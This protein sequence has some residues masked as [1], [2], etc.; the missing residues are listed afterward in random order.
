MSGGRSRKRLLGAFAALC[1]AA[2]IMAG[3]GAGAEEPLA[4]TTDPERM[5][6]GVV[7][8]RPVAEGETE[9]MRRAGIDSLRLWIPWAAVESTRDHYDW[10]GTD[11]VM[12]DLAAAGIDAFPFLFGT[13]EWAAHRDRF[14]CEREEC[15]P[16][17]PISIET[18]YAFARFAAAAVR[19][20]GPDGLFWQENPDLPQRPIRAWQIWNEPNL[21]RFYEPD[22]DASE[23][24]DLLRLTSAAIRGADPLAEVVLGGLFGPS[25][26]S[27]MIGARRFLKELYREPEIE[28]S[29]DG[30]AVHPYSPR[31]RGVLEQIRAARKVGRANDTGFDLWITEIGWSSAG[32]RDQNLVKTRR[33]QA[34]MLRKAFSRFLRRADRWNLRGAYWFAWRDTPRNVQVCAWCPGAGLLDQRGSPKPAY[35]ELRRLTGTP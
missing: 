33:E 21:A 27:R 4:G 14:G 9:R 12:R 13:P 24:A 22:A 20:Y 30:I 15:I 31:A 28:N 19:R 2:A 23:Y 7:P 29:F 16:Y 18:R 5:R 3:S 35:R 1:G 8:Q 10:S 6:V 11:A 25:S 26:T 17:A 32:R 34:R